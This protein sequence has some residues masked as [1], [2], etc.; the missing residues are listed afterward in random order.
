MATQ[1]SANCGK[2]RVSSPPEDLSHRRARLDSTSRTYSNLSAPGGIIPSLENMDKSLESATEASE[3]QRQ[4]E[5]CSSDEYSDTGFELELAMISEMQTLENNLTASSS[6]TTDEQFHCDGI[7]DA[8]LQTLL[9]ESTGEI[10]GENP[11][12]SVVRAFDVESRSAEDYDPDLQFSSPQTSDSSGT[13]GS[14]ASIQ[15]T[16]TVDW[17]DIRQQA[18]RSQQAASRASY[19]EQTPDPRATLKPS[20]GLSPQSSG[21][22]PQATW[23][24]VAVN[25]RMFNPSRTCFRL[26]EITE[27]KAAMMQRQPHAVYNVFARVLYS[28]RENFFRRQYFQLRDLLSESPPYLTGALLG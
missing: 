3:P 14:C 12:S 9:E 11:P 20:K 24:A 4:Q 1:P 17:E 10:V 23:T 15:S 2:R 18:S 5:I 16:D 19:F 28:S 22:M 26:T 8:A 21:L 25:M 6:S 7:D 13:I 27:S